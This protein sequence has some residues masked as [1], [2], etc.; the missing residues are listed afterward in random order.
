MTECSIFVYLYLV[1]FFCVLYTLACMFV[2]Y[3]NFFLA[4]QY[5]LSS[6]FL[7][8]EAMKRKVNAM[9]V[10]MADPGNTKPKLPRKNRLCEWCGENGHS[11]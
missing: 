11:E 1:T 6:Y 9:V 10:D 4:H 3:G 5:T 2:V 7:R 8:C